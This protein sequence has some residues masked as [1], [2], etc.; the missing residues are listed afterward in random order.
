MRKRICK[1]LD[2]SFYFL[3]GSQSP[4]TCC[5]TFR[6]SNSCSVFISAPQ[7]MPLVPELVIIM[8]K[9]SSQEQIKEKV[10]TVGELMVTV[11]PGNV[12]RLS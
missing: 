5:V 11:P 8:S 10:L 6:V 12:F 9:A 2:F 1:R 7:T 3:S 4:S